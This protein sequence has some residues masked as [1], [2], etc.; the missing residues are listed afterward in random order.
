MWCSTVKKITFVITNNRQ[1]DHNPPWHLLNIRLVLSAPSSGVWGVKPSVVTNSWAG[2]VPLIASGFTNNWAASNRNLIRQQRLLAMYNFGL[3]RQLLYFGF[4]ICHLS[5]KGTGRS[6]EWPLQ[7][8]AQVSLYLVIVWK[9]LCKTNCIQS[10]NTSCRPS[11]KFRNCF[12]DL[13]LE[14]H[15]S[16]SIHSVIHKP[17]SVKSM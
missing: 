3:A 16:I 11:Y 8:E 5:F 1:K 14:Y 15:N 7:L 13:C 4:R 17:T 12:K 2:C 9:P 6:K 10:N